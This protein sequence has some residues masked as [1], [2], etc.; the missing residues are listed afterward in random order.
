MI[1]VW[2]GRNNTVVVSAVAASMTLHLGAMQAIPVSIDIRPDDPPPT[3]IAPRSQGMLPVAILTTPTFDATTIAPA[4]LRL[5][6][7]GTEAAPVRVGRADVDRD[8]DTDL[9]AHFAV[10]DTGL[11]CGATTL[12][13]KGRTTDGQAIDGSESIET[14]GCR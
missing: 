4:T 3:I 1:S 11:E 10:Q 12:I 8:G 7:T 9:R 14:E 5:G 13:L 2:R 6:V